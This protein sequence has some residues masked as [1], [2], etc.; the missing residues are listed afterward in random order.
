VPTLFLG[1]AIDNFHR[2]RS[3]NHER[4]VKTRTARDSTILEFVDAI[5]AGDAMFPLGSSDFMDKDGE[6]F[7]RVRNDEK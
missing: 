5:G 7:I 3:R 2:T 6:R 1:I 4:D